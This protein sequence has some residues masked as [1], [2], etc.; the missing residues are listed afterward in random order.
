MEKWYM[1]LTIVNQAG[2]QTAMV[3]Y[4]DNIYAILEALDK[5]QIPYGGGGYRHLAV[6]PNG[7]ITDALQAALT[8]VIENKEAPPSIRE[9]N[10]L[11]EQ[12]Q[13][14]TVQERNRLTEELLTMPQAAISDAYPAIQRICTDRDM[15]HGNTDLKERL[16]QLREGYPYIRIQ[17]I[18]DGEDP[19]NE[20]AGIWV[21]CPATEEQIAETARAAGVESLEELHPNMIDGILSYSNLPLIEQDSLLSS[22]REVNQL[23]VAMEEH[24]VL[25]NIGKFKAVLY[26]EGCLSFEKAAELA[27]KLD[28]YKFF[29]KQ[30]LDHRLQKASYSSLD[31]DVLDKLDIE[32][33]PYGFIQ[34]ADAPGIDALMERQLHGCY[35][36][37]T[38][39]AL[40]KTPRSEIEKNKQH[41]AVDMA[42]AARQLYALE[43][44]LQGQSGTFSEW[45]RAAYELNED[46]ELSFAE[47]V[48]EIC[49]A[50]QY[51]DCQYGREIAQQLYNSLRIII[52]DEIRRA[53]RY[54]SYGGRLESLSGLARVGFFEWDPSH[55]EMLRAVAFVNAGGAFEDAVH[56]AKHECAGTQANQK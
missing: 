7:D 31:V 38:K 6:S 55:E 32:E 53:A 29:R 5:C 33:T 47:V 4:P 12:I 19:N 28:E 23:A 46:F 1:R 45:L 43:N 24:G 41:F 30:E 14:M 36:V 42:S 40:Y 17:L 44:D 11:G 26:F 25:Q 39:G 16:V 2:G 37:E 3:I 27:G 9:L 49:D 8:P 56:A 20:K 15:E 48:N 13:Q 54:L 50:I 35:V 10:Y 22:F 21:N 34:D 52:A 18:H 51:A